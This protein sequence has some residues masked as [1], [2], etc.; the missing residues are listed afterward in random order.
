MDGCVVD[1]CVVDGCVVDGF[2][3]V[4]VIPPDGIFNLLLLAVILFF[5]VSPSELYNIG[6]L[7]N[8]FF[9]IVISLVSVPLL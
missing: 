7:E 9:P 1:G 8:T 5:N 6:V 2:V 4:N 3:S